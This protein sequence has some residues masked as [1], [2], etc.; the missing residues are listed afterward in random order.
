LVF[1]LAGL[2]LIAWGQYSVGF[3]TLAVTLFLAATGL[4]A[5]RGQCARYA[6]AQ[7]RAILSDPVRAAAVRAAFADLTGE[8]SFRRAAA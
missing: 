5:M 6:V 7:V 2:G 3:Q 1:V 8:Q 4:P